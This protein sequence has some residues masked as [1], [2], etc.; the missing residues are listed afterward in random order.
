MLSVVLSSRISVEERKKI[1]EDK[2]GIDMT[3]KME[4]EMN[5]MCNLSDRIEEKAEQG[6]VLQMLKDGLEPEK[7]V[8][9]LS[10][11]TLADVKKMK[12]QF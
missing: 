5:L 10:T 7:I 12:E 11:L 1:L 6:V 3:I 8:T 9:Y 2:Y 4:R